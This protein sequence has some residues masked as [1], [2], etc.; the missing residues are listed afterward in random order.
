MFLPRFFALVFHFY[1][2]CVFFIYTYNIPPGFFSPSTTATTSTSTVALRPPNRVA[3]RVAWA[4]VNAPNNI[5]PF[6]WV[7][8]PTKHPLEPPVPPRPE[9]ARRQQWRT[10]TTAR[11]C[12]S[13]VR[14]HATS[15]RASKRVTRG[16]TPSCAQLDNGG[17]RRPGGLCST[18]FCACVR[19]YKHIT[20]ARVCLR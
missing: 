18:I 5:D 19:V 3:H 1:W 20:P 6:R 14:I 15:E 9:A 4:R 11:A 2:G 13:T 8:E 16:N 10:T 12:V 17:V 7:I